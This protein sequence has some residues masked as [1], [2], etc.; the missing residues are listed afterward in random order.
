MSE[1]YET[2]NEIKLI[3]EALDL[4]ARNMSSYVVK[5]YQRL[6][7]VIESLKHLSK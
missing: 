4:I 3:T 5:D 2:G 1:V 6:L 7:E